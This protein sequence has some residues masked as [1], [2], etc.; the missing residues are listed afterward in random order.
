MPSAL[1]SA[2]IP[3]LLSLAAGCA[4]SLLETEATDTP[5]P[6]ATPVGDVVTLS[7]DGDLTLS[8]V[9]ASASP[10]CS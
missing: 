7:H 4:P 9:D 10:P 8:R 5:T 6:G 3:T 1:R 2:L